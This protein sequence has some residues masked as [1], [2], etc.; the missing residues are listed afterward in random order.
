MKI[1]LAQAIEDAKT[2]LQQAAPGGLTAES[3]NPFS[4]IN[5]VLFSA[6]GILGIIAVSLMI[7]AGALWLTA[8][9]N[10]D[11]VGKAKKIIRTTIFGIIIVGLAYAITSFVISFFLQ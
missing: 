2:G 10:D 7:Y 11:Q 6:V 4:L 3:V 9:G 8:A 1:F 5:T